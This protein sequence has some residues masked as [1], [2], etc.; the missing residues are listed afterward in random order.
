MLSFTIQALGKIMGYIIVTCC[1]TA[2][3]LFPS[4][5]SYVFVDQVLTY[6]RLGTPT[7]PNF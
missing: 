6:S 7:A 2:V 1:V 3:P 4:K 5:R